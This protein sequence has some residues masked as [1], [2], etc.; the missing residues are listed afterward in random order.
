MN[1]NSDG[2]T[3]VQKVVKACAISDD[4]QGLRWSVVIAWLNFAFLYWAIT[5][6]SPTAITIGLLLLAVSCGLG[7]YF[8]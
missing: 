8:G 7:A 1:S 2:D 3:L 5:T 6:D 4:S